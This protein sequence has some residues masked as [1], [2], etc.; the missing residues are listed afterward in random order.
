MSTSG[1]DLPLRPR[2]KCLTVHLTFPLRDCRAA[3]Y[4]RVQNWSWVFAWKLS[5]CPAHYPEEWPHQLPRVQ[6]SNL[7]VMSGS[8]SSSPHT[9]CIPIPTS[10]VHAIGGFPLD[11]LNSLFYL[12]PLLPIWVEFS[13]YSQ[14]DRSLGF[15]L[16]PCPISFCLHSLPLPPELSDSAPSSLSVTANPYGY[17]YKA[18]PLGRKTGNLVNL[19]DSFVFLP[20]AP[21]DFH[22]N[23]LQQMY[24]LSYYVPHKKRNTHF[25]F[26]LV[27]TLNLIK[28]YY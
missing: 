11:Y 25:H 6:V 26:S 12:H 20:S 4:W 17:L 3:Q 27:S 7:G 19:C 8:S 9:H 23:S 13:T 14:N 15:L 16:C 21:G 1:L 2:P 24:H 18:S 5:A 10:P 28:H 22:L